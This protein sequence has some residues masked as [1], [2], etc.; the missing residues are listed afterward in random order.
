MEKPTLKNE[1]EAKINGVATVENNINEAKEY[2]LEMKKYYSTLIFSEEQ[3]KEAKEERAS[4]NKIVKK[5]ADYRNSIV[6]DFKKP[7]EEFE[8]TAKETEKI[9][10]ETS[11]L[12]DV[13]VKKYES[14]VKEKKKEECLKIYKNI[15]GDLK[16]LVS[17]EK[18][19]NDKWL[20]KG[21]KLQDVEND[22]KT[23]VDK[24]NSGIEAIKV[25]KSEFETEIINTFL[26]DYDVTKAI[27]KNTELKEKKEAIAKTT[28]AKEETKKE[29]VKEMISNPI[30]INEVEPIREYTLK[31][32]ATYSK[33]VELR[34]FMDI[35]DIVYEKI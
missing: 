2:A 30:E 12:I 6:A 26:I 24:V 17:F 11:S 27:I 32:K 1:I 3:I 28:E 31:V 5:I 23:I 22:I 14:E 29:V 13:Q 16:D 19:F 33:L 20:N 9:L 7:I 15:I 25:L 18:I 10:K 21:T 34:K 4:V 8:N 35:N